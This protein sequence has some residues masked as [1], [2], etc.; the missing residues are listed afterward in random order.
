MLI[1]DR[2]RLRHHIA[3]TIR[4][5]QICEQHHVRWIRGCFQLHAVAQAERSGQTKMPRVGNVERYVA[6]M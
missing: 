1:L 3:H 6:Q 5:D 2:Y 4:S